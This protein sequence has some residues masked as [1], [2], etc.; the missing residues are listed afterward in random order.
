MQLINNIKY[1]K[2]KTIYLKKK[3]IINLVD[4]ISIKLDTINNRMT[5]EKKIVEVTMVNVLKKAWG[6]FNMNG[7]DN[8]QDL[9]EEIYDDAE[10]SEEYEEEDDNANKGLFGIK[11]NKKVQPMN[12]AVK[13]VILQPTKIEQATE[14]CDLLRDR[15][16]IIMNLEFLNKDVARRMID[17]VS[18][19]AHVLD[20]H[21][22]KISNS[23]FLVAPFNYDIK[24]DE[25]NETRTKNSAVQFLK[26]N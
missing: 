17:M 3:H 22:E 5:N 21:M 15:K 20:G 14:V 12:S 1:Y 19:A 4:N 11:S 2:K 10:Y 25:F 24:M 7:T 16:S 6:M 8:D 26:A 13:M 18:G 9:D 23:I